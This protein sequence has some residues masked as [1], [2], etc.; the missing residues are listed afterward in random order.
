[1]PAIRAAL[2]KAQMSLAD[3]DRVEINEAF[4]PQIMAC[5]RELGLNPETTNIN[6]GAIA[7]GHPLGASGSRITMHLAHAIKNGEAKTA[8]GSACIGG[9]QGIALVLKQAV[10]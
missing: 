5:A 8:V 2:S 6:G 10:L 9:G 4:A 3:V 1:V 7:L